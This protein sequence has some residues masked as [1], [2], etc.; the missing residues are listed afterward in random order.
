MTEYERHRRYL[1]LLWITLATVFLLVGS[2]NFAVDAFGMFGAPRISGFNE[3]KPE[4]GTHERMAKGFQI[5]FYGPHGLILGTSRADVG[6]DP[7]HPAWNETAQPVYNSALSSGRI[8]EMYA[9]LKH[10]Q[11]HG[12]LQ[13]VVMSIDLMMFN[14]NWRHEADFQP[15]R[16]S[17]PE[18][19]NWSLEWVK[20]G[21]L[22]LF[23]LDGI[24]SSLKTLEAQDNPTVTNYFANGARD[25]RNK[26][27]YVQKHGG[28]FNLF[29]ENTEYDL[30][31]PEGWPLFALEPARKEDSPLRTLERIARY[32]QEND[33]DLRVFISPIHASKQ[34]VIWQ[35]GLGPELEQW[36]REATRILANRNVP[37]WDFSGY[38]R[39]T[40]EPFP[41]AGDTHTRMNYYWEGSHYRREVGNLILDRVLGNGEAPADFGIRL[42][43]RNVEAYLESSRAA[44]QAYLEENQRDLAAVREL[45][46][47]TLPA[48]KK[49]VARYRP[50]RKS[51]GKTITPG[52]AGN[53]VGHAR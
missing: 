45:V 5:R 3:M 9:Y 29:L 41:P 22:S 7:D 36:K 11:A 16:L 4:I 28:H 17:D 44:R 2:F 33:I 20:D 21:L 13:Q 38:N 6:L 14:A 53:A 39:I 15:G 30:T 32:C 23:S 51:A 37:L 34:E 42:T 8:E 25:S 10:A 27:A 26:W 47:T 50:A 31:A 48:R 24:Q 19:P 43:P 12:P 1:R 35:L 49:L 40:T 46:A 52:L 18:R